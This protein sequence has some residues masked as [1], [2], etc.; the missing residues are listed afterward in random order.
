MYFLKAPDTSSISAYS[1]SISSPIFLSDITRKINN[2]ISSASDFN[3]SSFSLSLGS[4]S[5]DGRDFETAQTMTSR[6]AVYKSSSEFLDDLNRIKENAIKF[7]GL[8]SPVCVWASKLF[9]IGSEYIKKNKKI[10]NILE[11]KVAS[12]YARM[13]LQP[14]MLEILESMVNYTNSGL[15]RNPV[16]T[17]KIPKYLE[18]IKNP[19]DLNTIRR[20]INFFK[21]DSI[22]SFS[23]DCKKILENSIKFN[24]EK[25]LITGYARG[26]LYEGQR[27]LL[28]LKEF[29]KM[30]E[31]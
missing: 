26:T 22:K 7:N 25:S 29:I 17:K 10:L 30:Y 21:Y 28:E 27:K 13:E 23:Q 9:E 12:L 14:F 15:F 5:S 1:T 8:D 11:E 24:G 20:K 18:V 2:L 19:M 4:N 6:R 3:T 31:K 16:N